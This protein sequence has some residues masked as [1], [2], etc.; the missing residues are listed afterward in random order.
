MNVAAENVPPPSPGDV[1]RIRTRTYLVEDVEGCAGGHVIRSACLDDDAQ[2]QSLQALWELE[3]DTEILDEEAW[4]SIGQRG[5]DSPR[6][7]GAYVH[8]LRWNCVTATNPRL[9]QAPFRAGIRIDPYQLD[10]LRKALLLPRVNLFI[11]D[12]VGLGKTIEA[13]LIASELLLR[14]RVRDVVVSCPPSML[15]QWKDELEARF[16]LT[17]EVLDR[18]YVEKVRQER[19]FGVNP[20]TTF[21]RF[22][23]SQRL[24]IDETY[25]AP[26]R[27]WLDN[28]RPG[29]LL[30][31]D[32]AHH[33]APSSGA[34]YAIDSRITRAVRD[35][36]P[37]FEH[38]L[39]LSATPH[40]GHSNSFSALLEILDSQRFCR[41]VKVLKSHL[42][43]VMVRRLKEDVREVAGGFPKRNVVQVDLDSDRVPED[44][45]ELVLPKLLDQYRLVRQKRMEGAS[46]RK[47][48]EA[49][50]L[51]SGLQ[52]RLLSSVEAFSRTLRVHRRTMER[53][54]AQDATEPSSKAESASGKADRKQLTLLTSSPSSDDDF[55]QL[56]EDDLEALEN[57]QIET[58]TESTAGDTARADEKAEKELLD[59]MLAVAEQARGLPDARIRYLVEWIKKHMCPGV[60]LPGQK[61]QTDNARWNDVRLLVFTEWEDTKR[62]VVNM[63]RAAVAG[64]QLEEHRIEVFHG[65]TPPDKREKIK[66]AFNAPPS[67][68]PVRILV[69]TDAAREGL[70]LQAHCHHLFHIDVPWNPSRL[71]QRNG[72]ID[73]KLQ[74]APEVFC[75][76]FV[77]TERPEDRVLQVLVR[78]TKTIREEL[79]SLSQV[80][81]ARLAETLKGGIHHDQAQLLADEIDQADLDPEKRATTEEE[82]DAARQRQ[83][84]L[85]KQIDQLDRR[86]TDARKWIGLDMASLRDALSCSLEMLGAEP[87]QSQAGP[88]GEPAR[89]VFP[90]LD[91]RQGGDPS[92][93]TTLDTLRAPPEDDES[94]FQ[95]RK[96]APIRPVVFEAPEGVDDS[97]VQLHLH[98]RVVQ[99]LLGRFLSQGFVHH[100]LSRACLAQSQDNI[101]RVVLLGRLSLYG[102]GA[103]RLHEELLSVTARWSDG[104]ARKD[105][106]SPYA[107]DAEAKTMDLLEHAL[108]PS[109][110]RE[111]PESVRQRRLASIPVDIEQLLPHLEERGNAARLDAEKALAE[112]GQAEAKEMERILEEQKKRILAELGKSVD[113]QL[114][115]F[116]NDDERRQYESNRRYWERW[117][118]NVEGDIEREPARIMDFYKVTSYRIEPVGIAYLCPATE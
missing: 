27:D 84:E 65:P 75:H 88:K 113:R 89:F 11:A 43:N 62:Y 80:L 98:H 13:G 33:A 15:L 50:L 106:L 3:L 29:S 48:A 9:F 53:I 47:Q 56:G 66:R 25:A 21:P 26:L 83:E 87:L 81:E 7:F 109:A 99:R 38:R 102:P 1:V 60:H 108:Q 97:V 92:W 63:L 82:L 115:L 34:K 28:F 103:T 2:G 12:D 74:P 32:E 69:A 100:D 6:H 101:P 35:L 55:S 77:Y 59:K 105:A 96:N 116:S 17:F 30:I 57:E 93:A 44:A 39:F 68:H 76:Y 110:Q 111:L 78:K 45:P 52:Q 114:T 46:K 40:N 104:A 19:G 118:E 5:F 91:T 42:D 117:I 8:A 16:G 95:W 71:E 36:A 49:G 107:R 73:R 4:K 31:L 72:R 23:I 112:R 58:S 14:R 94:G 90:N 24:L 79:G 18:K 85:K 70:N 86:V 37:R 22:L 10:P 54:W 61:P 67:E 51:I 41:G 64:T 20:W